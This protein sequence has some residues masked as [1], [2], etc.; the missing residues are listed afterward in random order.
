MVKCKHPHCSKEIPDDRYA[1]G[2]HW[3]LL[4]F[5][6]REMITLGRKRSQELYEKGDRAAAAKWASISFY[7]RQLSLLEGEQKSSKE[8]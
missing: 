6:I 8:S 2:E 7:G 4:G 3:M 5:E 1:C